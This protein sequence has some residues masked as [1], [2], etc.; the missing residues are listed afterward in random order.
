MGM[1]L[2]NGH[3][4]SRCRLS[5]YPEQ[6]SNIWEI[7]ETNIFPCGSLQCPEGTYCGNPNDFGLPF[8]RSET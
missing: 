7:D 2:F 1:S 3:I 5:E 8:N 6:G 4:E